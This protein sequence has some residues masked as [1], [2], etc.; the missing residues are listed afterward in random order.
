[1]VALSRN[2]VLMKIALAT[3]SHWP[4][5]APEESS[6]IPALTAKGVDAQPAV[7]SDPSIDW[8]QFDRVVIRSCWDYHLRLDEFLRWIETVPS[9]RN[10]A[11]VVRWN[12]HKSYLLELERKGVRIPATLLIRKGAAEDSRAP[13][14]Q[15]RVIVKPAVS[16]SAYE[17]HLFDSFGQAL[18]DIQRLARDHDVVIQEFVPE[19]IGDGEWSL[20]YFDR[21]FSHAVKKAPKAGDFRVQQE[22]GGSALAAVASELLLRTAQQ[23]LDAVEG[24]LLYARVDLVDAAKGPLLMELEL[25]EPSLFLGTDPEATGRFAAAI[26]R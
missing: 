12:S 11:T 25:I 5:L 24:Q 2:E 23:A 26:A 7:W 20:I 21:Q 18:D 13:M 6:L 17:T 3:S 1:M 4:Q 19:V 15:G 10:P 16:A 8:S 9:L 14:I 22:L